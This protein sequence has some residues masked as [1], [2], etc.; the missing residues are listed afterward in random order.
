MTRGNSPW[1]PLPTA[2]INWAGETSPK[3]VQFDDFYYSSLSGVEESQYI[4][5][6]GNG[7]PRRWASHSQPS[8]CIVETGFGTG[9]NFLLTWKLWREQ[10]EPRPRLHFLSVEKHPLGIEDMRRALASWPELEELTIALLDNYPQPI[11]GQHRIVLEDGKLILDLWWEEAEH[12]LS[13]LAGQENPMVDAWY[14]DGFS[15][16][17][18]HLMW[19]ENIFSCM[20]KSCR[21]GATFATFTAAGFVRRALVDTGF[22]VSRLPGFGKKREC[23]H[24]IFSK[25]TQVR[26]LSPAKRE[27][28]TPWEIRN[29]S[30]GYPRTAIV[31]GAGIAGCTAAAALARRNINVTVI[32]GNTVA[33][34]GSGNDQGVLYTRLSHKHSPLTDFSLQS[35]SFAHRFYRHYLSSGALREGIDGALC[36]SFHQSDKLKELATLAPLL[37]S[38]PGLAQVL[39][40]TEANQLLGIE[41]T[42]GGYWYPG[43]GWMRPSSVCHL[44]LD[45]DRIQLMESTGAVSLEQVDGRWSAV[46]AGRVLAE[47][48]CA[49]IAAGTASASLA[50]LDWLPLK[51]IRGQT[52]TL[53]STDESSSLR[54]ALCHK[55]Y[56]SPARLE[57]HCI[58]ATFDIDDMDTHIREADHRFNLDSLA[59]AVP[60]WEASLA[61]LDEQQL[62]GR[63]G[64]RCAS[65]DYLPLIGPVPNKTMFLQ[66]YAALRKNAR[67]AIPSYG[68]YMRGLYLSTGHGSRGLTSTALAAETR[69][70]PGAVIAVMKIRLKIMFLARIK[71]LISACGRGCG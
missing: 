49:I 22:V 8:F 69:A 64:Y 46:S 62:E 31:I 52:T 35:Y 55:G 30:P 68:D 36:G 58:G 67:K 29:Y 17:R 59:T 4:F 47:A 45:N 12:A 44:L 39:T 48:E 15:P 19:T 11:P 71:S 6:Q 57:S 3:S 18:N 1:Q 34:A 63:V 38:V 7:L 10:P 41:Q 13:E 20:A 61:A 56:I 9:L 24:G 26:G 32:E 43:S 27:T 5:L 33:N 70:L 14:L 23:L 2:E 50:C 65:P 37:Q 21:E 16:N 40:A 53:P 66:N 51:A 42:K 28:G 54:A 60:D 25:L